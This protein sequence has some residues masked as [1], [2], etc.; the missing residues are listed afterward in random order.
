[1]KKHDKKWIS[2]CLLK[3]K[4]IE[5]KEIIEA[6]GNP[7]NRRILASPSKSKY[8]LK[9]IM[10][11]IPVSIFLN[12][13]K[14]LN[15]L[16]K[17]AVSKLTE[18]KRFIESRGKLRVIDKRKFESFVLRQM[19]LYQLIVKPQKSHKISIIKSVYKIISR[20]TKCTS[21]NKYQK[22]LL[23]GYI[24]FEFGIIANSEYSKDSAN[25]TREDNL[26]LRRFLDKK[27]EYAVKRSKKQ[28]I[29]KLISSNVIT[30]FIGIDMGKKVRYLS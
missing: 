18:I 9:R 13:E 29:D 14:K 5:F 8:M 26:G 11:C 21:A 27:V 17:E 25:G 10:N 1:M 16:E 28:N 15:S 6:L 23:T 22:R 20:T 4:V 2:I 30:K 3:N 7:H 19:P 24:C 12:K